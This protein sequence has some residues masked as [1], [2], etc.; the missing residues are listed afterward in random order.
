MKIILILISLLLI[1]ATACNDDFI[2][3]KP[4]DKISDDNYW[5]SASDIELY[6]NQFYPQLF[7]NSN[8]F[9]RND[10][11]SDNQA[12]KTRTAYIWNESVVPTTGGGWGQSDWQQ[13]PRVNYA[14]ARITDL[15]KTDEV[16][17]Y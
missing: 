13:I 10:D 2:D 7:P 15:A 9:F 16:K 4:E 11:Y 17:R 14:L 8:T 1:T 5:A 3:L 6:A 12:Y